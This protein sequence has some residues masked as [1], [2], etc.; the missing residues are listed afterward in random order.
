MLH[1]LP[2]QVMHYIVAPALLSYSAA[3]PFKLLRGFKLLRLKSLFVETEKQVT[4]RTNW[5]KQLC[6][7][8]L[9]FMVVSHIIACMVYSLTFVDDDREGFSWLDHL[10][11]Q[12]DQD[13][14]CH[15][16]KSQ[17]WMYLVC[18][19]YSTTVIT[20]VGFG[21]MMPYSEVQ[22]VGH[23]L[24][25]ALGACHN[26]MLISSIM[27]VFA[28]Y[29]C[30]RR[31]YLTARVELDNFLSSRALSK[32]LLEEIQMHF[33][34]QWSNTRFMNENAFM[35]RYFSY[36]IR[37][38]VRREMYLGAVKGARPP[39]AAFGVG[40][41]RPLRLARA[42]GSKLFEGAPVALL[43]ELL[44]RVQLGVY[45]KDD[46]ICKHGYYGSEVFLLV[47]G[48]ARIHRRGEKTRAE[49]SETFG[50]AVLR[51]AP[52]AVLGARRARAG[53]AR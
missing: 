35:E 18:M 51:G 29:N 16:S 41:R 17:S 47:N 49:A 45:K 6:Q 3:R 48:A 14:G 25:A 53:A 40:R 20:T 8:V 5:K 24:A 1:S 12:W 33:D 26:A 34:F 38:K 32:D 4:S 52:P 30:Q 39:V 22:I 27:D 31:D 50:H 10:C 44:E 37:R 9:R 21:N 43:I 36:D 7:I 2:W 46:V 15:V 13:P 28:Q 19:Y 11:G 42:A 23:T